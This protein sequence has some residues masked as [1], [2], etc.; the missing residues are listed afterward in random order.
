MLPPYSHSRPVSFGLPFYRKGITRA[1]GSTDATSLAV[2]VIDPVFH[3]PSVYD[4]RKV[5]AEDIAILTFVTQTATETSTGFL[6][7]PLFRQP[8]ADL[9]EIPH[10]FGNRQFDPL[11]SLPMLEIGGIE[12]LKGYH[13]GSSPSGHF[14]EVFG[15]GEGTVFSHP[16]PLKEAIHIPLSD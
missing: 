15:D 10:P 3:H 7:G 12:L 9:P 2:V 5:R 4:D 16:D 11:V 8:R 1:L 6:Q 14:V 13:M